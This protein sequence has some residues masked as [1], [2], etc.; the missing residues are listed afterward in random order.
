MTKHHLNAKGEVSKCAA[1]NGRARLQVI[2][3][4]SAQRPMLLPRMM[5]TSKE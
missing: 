2:V 5:D 1:S 4:I 3:S